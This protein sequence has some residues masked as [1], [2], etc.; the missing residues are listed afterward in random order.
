MNKICNYL[1]KELKLIK[2]LKKKKTPEHIIKLM[3]TEDKKVDEFDLEK[4]KEFYERYACKKRDLK[5]QQIYAVKNISQKMVN[6]EDNI[7]NIEQ[8]A[9]KLRAEAEEYFMKNCVVGKTVSEMIADTVVEFCYIKYTS[10]SKAFAW[11]VFGKYILENI[12]NNTLKKT[13]KTT[14][15]YLSSDGDIRYLYKNFKEIEIDIISEEKDEVKKEE[16]KTNGI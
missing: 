14:I 9:K 11:N 13:N 5:L 16:V 12:K 15:P 2:D 6:T 7:V 3:Q 8:Y 10:K 1:E 4:I